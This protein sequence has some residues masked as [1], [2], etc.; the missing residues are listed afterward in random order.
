MAGQ[1]RPD[2]IRR[3]AEEPSFGLRRFATT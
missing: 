1:I 2:P 3:K